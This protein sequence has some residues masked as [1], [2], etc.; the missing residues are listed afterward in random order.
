MVEL[1]YRIVRAWLESP[2]SGIIELDHDWTGRARPR[3]TL[4]KQC[5][6]LGGLAPAPGLPAGRAYGYFFNTHG[7]VSFVLPLERGCDIDP[8]RD[9]VYL[10]GNFNG[11][12]QAVGDDAWRLQPAELEGQRVLM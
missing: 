7:E 11:W 10:A 6:A 3:F 8:A 5:P 2:S 1:S 9:T 12:P 4:G